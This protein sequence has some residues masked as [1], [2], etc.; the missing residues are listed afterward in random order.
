[1]D[2][3]DIYEEFL[4]EAAFLWGQRARWL[5]S[6]LRSLEDVTELEERLLAHLDGLVVGG[7]PAAQALL[8]PAVEE[9]DEPERLSAAAFALL[10]SPAPAV[11]EGLLERW[12]SAPEELQPAYQRALELSLR[13]GLDEVLLRQCAQQEPDSRGY[14]LEV[15]AFRGALPAEVARAQLQSRQQQGLVAALHSLCPL[16]REVVYGQLPR[17]LDSELIPVRLAAIKAGLVAGARAAWAACLREVRERRE[18][19]PEAL[20]LVALCGEERELEVL[21]PLLDDPPLRADVLWA[22]GFSGRVAAADA[23]LKVMDGPPRLARLAGES[24]SAITGL[25]LEGEYAVAPPEEDSLPPLEEDIET[26][27]TPKPEDDLPL[28]AGEQIARWWTQARKN[29]TARGR[30]L[31]GQALSAEVLLQAL[32]QEP[33]RRRHLH[34]LELALR[35]HG[36][37]Q[38]QTRGWTVRQRTE[39]ARAR[40]AC[41]RLPAFRLV[42]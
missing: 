23:C 12:A 13:S 31:R 9:P 38:V 40:L 17:L 2:M 7:E 28:P 3:P 5:R 18:G 15:L 34:A 19:L 35:S 22:L 4:D 42:T 27:L 11:L 21:L 20:I 41:A 26:D 14:L 37:L 24:F 8:L 39:L 10:A 6:P 29:F 25:A 16:P 30:W 1:M 36:E 33:M 32:E